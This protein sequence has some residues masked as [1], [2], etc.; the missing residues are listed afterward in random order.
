MQFDAPHILADRLRILRRV[1]QSRRSHTD[2]SSERMAI[3][4]RMPSL[5]GCACDTYAL[6]CPATLVHAKYMA[7]HNRLWYDRMG[8]ILAA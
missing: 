6:A 2:D 5:N 3:E 1:R 4:I 7:V 8:R